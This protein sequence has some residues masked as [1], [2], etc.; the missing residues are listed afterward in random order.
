MI[1]LDMRNFDGRR[2]TDVDNEKHCIE[3]VYAHFFLD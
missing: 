1:Q 3:F 2:G